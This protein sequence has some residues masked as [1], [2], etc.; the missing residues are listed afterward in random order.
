M[1]SLPGADREAAAFSERVSPRFFRLLSRGGDEL[2]GDSIASDFAT[3]QKT[4][5]TFLKHV[6][7]GRDRI[8]RVG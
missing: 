5:P 7:A 3:D 6:F 4:H 8:L 2:R 1:S